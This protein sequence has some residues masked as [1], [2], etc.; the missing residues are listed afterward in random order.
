MFQ[1]GCRIDFDPIDPFKI[2]KEQHSQEY[3]KGKEK[4]KAVCCCE[5]EE[6]GAGA[7]KE[8][9]EQEQ[10][11]STPKHYSDTDMEDLEVLEV[12][13]SDFQNLSDDEPPIAKKRRYKKRK[14]D[15]WAQEI[16]QDFATKRGAEIKNELQSDRPD[17]Q[18]IMDYFKSVNREIKNANMQHSEPP[19]IDTDSAVEYS[20]K[21]ESEES[22]SGEP[23]RV[24]GLEYRMRKEYRSLSRGKP[25]YWWPVG[26][27][28]QVFVRYGSKRSL[29]YR[30]RAGSSQPYDPR[31]TELVLSKTRGNTKV[32][33]RT[34][35]LPKEVWKYSR[36]SVLDIIGVGWKVNED[37]ADINALAL[38]RP[39]QE[40]YPHTKVLVKWKDQQISLERRGFVRRIAN[41]GNFNGDRMIYLK[42]KELENSYWGY[43]VEEDIDND[44]DSSDSGSSDDTDSETSQPRR[45]YKKSKRRAYSSRPRR[46]EGSDTNS[47]D[48]AQ[49]KHRSSGRVRDKK[50]KS[51]KESKTIDTEID[52]LEEKL[53]RLKVEREKASR[54]GQRRQRRN[55]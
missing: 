36:D 3:G 29:I 14:M 45:R 2:V 34:D 22:E 41:S 35:G 51:S 13:D 43:N 17:L 6:I 37:E 15:I 28:T 38:I 52:S 40:V 30:V 55:Y 20:A 50:S 4:T 54:R 53:K 19:D 21:S 31:T 33:S 9:E 23:D 10:E 25:L 18:K 1:T 39:P 46:R 47:D 7:G 5:P 16:I 11:Q 12:L 48:S 49:K 44:P 27:G 24:D 8:Q 42:A 32:V 26:T